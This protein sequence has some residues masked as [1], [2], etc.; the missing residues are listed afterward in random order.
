MQ[1]MQQELEALRAS[2]RHLRGK[3]RDIELDNDDLEKSERAISS[4]LSDVEMRYNKAIE[5]TALLEQ[6]LVD[7]ARLEEELQRTKDELR[8]NIEELA[9][10]KTAKNEAVANGNSAR[11]R[12]EELAQQ[13]DHIRTSGNVPESPTTPIKNSNTVSTAKEMS[14]MP[15][16]DIDSADEGAQS[17]APTSLGNITLH[18]SRQAPQT[19]DSTAT[20]VSPAHLAGITRSSR[21]QSL[22]GQ[23]MRASYSPATARE[24]RSESIINDMRGL[25]LRMQSMSKSLNTRRESLMAGSAIPRPTPRK[26]TTTAYGTGKDTIAFP[27]T[28]SSNSI[29][30]KGTFDDSDS[31]GLSSTR[32]P[33]DSFKSPTMNRPSSRTGPSIYTAKLGELDRS[34]LKSSRPASRLSHGTGLPRPETPSSASRPST[35]SQPGGATAARAYRR[36]SLGPTTNKRL[37]RL[38]DGSAPPLPV[39]P[40]TISGT[41]TATKRN[42]LA[43]SVRKATP[44]VAQPA[45]R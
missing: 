29:D 26:S 21:M 1:H 22:P 7:K 31:R 35:P 18:N 43:N 38:V 32:L 42:S 5:R 34:M 6:E 41:T 28:S 30:S 16:P 39:T 13:L 14:T 36:V 40:N 25:T 9:V 15:S 17:S 23:S 11:M 27:R 24:K 10:L 2:E 33:S 37:S 19:S 20:V 3:L 4:T 12:V 44:S 8:D 45:W